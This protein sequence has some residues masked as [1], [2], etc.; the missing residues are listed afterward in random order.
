MPYKEIQHAVM[1]QQLED[2]ARH[3]PKKLESNPNSVT[4]SIETRAL[5][6]KELASIRCDIG[7]MQM[8]VT[9]LE[10]LLK[11]R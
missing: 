1:C 2:R 5:A 8:R 6:L 4:I 3:E 10:E 11:T 7:R 9:K